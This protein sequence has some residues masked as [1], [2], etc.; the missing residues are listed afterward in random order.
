MSYHSSMVESLASPRRTYSTISDF[1]SSRLTMHN[2]ITKRVLTRS[3]TS[4]PPSHGNNLRNSAD[5]SSKTSQQYVPRRSKRLAPK[6]T[7]QTRKAHLRFSANQQHKLP[8]LS[9]VDLP[10]LL[11]RPPSPV[12]VKTPKK[13]RSSP[14]THEAFPTA[15]TQQALMIQPIGT[16]TSK[17]MLTRDEW[18][19]MH[20]WTWEGAW[21]RKTCM[22]RHDGRM[23]EENMYVE[24]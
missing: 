2:R 4:T 13:R 20:S 18:C 1:A 10:A 5:C 15:Q 9:T 17:I 7:T 19:R 21:G 14:L 8:F 11:E 3:H 12:P 16:R 6:V 23:G 22:S 24:A